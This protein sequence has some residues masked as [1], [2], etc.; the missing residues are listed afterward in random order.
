MRHIAVARFRRNRLVRMILYIS[1]FLLIFSLIASIIKY[2]CGTFQVFGGAGL[3]EYT[4][5]EKYKSYANYMVRLLIF[6]LAPYYS[7]T[8]FLYPICFYIGF[9]GSLVTIFLTVWMEGCAL[10][11][12]QDGLKGRAAFRKRFNIPLYRITSVEKGKSR[13]LTIVCGTAHYQI[14]HIK[15]RE[16]IYKA[17]IKL[18]E[19]RPAEPASPQNYEVSA[20]ETEGVYKLKPLVDEGIITQEEFLALQQYSYG[21]RE[22]FVSEETGE[23]PTQ[24]RPK[25]ENDKEIRYQTKK[26]KNLVRI[27]VAVAAL[28][29]CILV[30]VLALDS[31]GS[32]DES[33]SSYSYTYSDPYVLMVK[34]TKNSN[35]GITYGAAFDSFFSYPTWDHF[36][37]TTGEHVVEFEGYFL[38][39]G[40]RAKAKIQFLLDTG[41]GT[42][43]VYH[44]SI[45]GKDQ[46]RLVLAAMIQKV[47]ESY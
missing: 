4:Y 28:A 18:M 30:L 11:V 47:F 19:E 8:F 37:S 3:R 31:C 6:D 41:N 35:Y 22:S 27:I 1:L 5:P 9:A 33:G 26:R 21:Q 10:L 2:H 23:I 13:R 24:E 46:S 43:T 14:Y 25:T 34:T 20:E 40:S 7:F 42:M 17:L 39:D 44:L 15:N 38:Y 36:I 29:I 45:N 12:R 16:E 32:S